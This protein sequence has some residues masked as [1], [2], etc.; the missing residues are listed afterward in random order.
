MI[1]IECPNCGERNSGEFRFG[2]EYNPRPAESDK[3]SAEEWTEYLYMRDNLS[4]EQ[5]EWWFHRAGC[6]LWF[7]ARRDTYT[8]QVLETLRWQPRSE[9]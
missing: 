5:L 8:N 3:I 2:G 7:L 6:D 1:L 4:G 9:T